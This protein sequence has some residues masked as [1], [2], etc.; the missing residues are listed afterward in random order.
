[1]HYLQKY[2]SDQVETL[3]CAV[4]VDRDVLYVK[5]EVSR[6]TLFLVA[7]YNIISTPTN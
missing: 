5:I 2:T 4:H 3:Q 6:D 7:S 1:M